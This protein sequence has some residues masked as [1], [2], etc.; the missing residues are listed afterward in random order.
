MLNKNKGDVKKDF[1][2]FQK[3]K[4]LSKNAGLTKLQKVKKGD[5][6]RRSFNYDSNN[7]SGIK[8]LFLDLDGTVLLGR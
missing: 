2:V 7:D 8:A 3:S 6:L 1:P 5:K 4:K